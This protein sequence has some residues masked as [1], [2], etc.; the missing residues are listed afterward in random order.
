MTRDIARLL[1]FAGRTGCRLAVMAAPAD[2]PVRLERLDG[3]GALS[4]AAAVIANAA[5]RGLVQRKG[6]RLTL[7]P[8]ADAF[9]RRF[10]AAREAAFVDQHRDIEI[11][12]LVE[13]GES[14]PVRVNAAESPL[15]QLARLKGRDGGAWFS[16]DAIG[17][18][19][20]LARDFHFAG[21]QPRLTQTYEPRIGTSRRGTPGDGVELKD[22]VMAARLRVSRAVA[23]MGPD[24]AGVA[25]DACCFEK[26]LE[27]I[28][29]ERLWPAR[30]AKL[31]LK[32]ALMALHRHYNPPQPRASHAWGEEGFRPD[33]GDRP[34]R[35]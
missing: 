33:L 4:L 35:G 13:A 31:M 32:T 26:G 23:A 19:M 22:S 15:A 11:V 5:A 17:A 9:L 25:L 12:D 3:D 18:G 24:L 10:L 6:N 29:R 2:G 14:R 8:E 16:A 28:E 30:S 21:L 34:D 27:A 7:L 20:R 1:R